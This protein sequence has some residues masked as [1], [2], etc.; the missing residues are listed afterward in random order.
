VRKGKNSVAVL[1]TSARFFFGAKLPLETRRP[2]FSWE[3]SAKPLQ[4][5]RRKNLNSR[6]VVF[7]RLGTAPPAF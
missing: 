6:F 1:H 4:F 2:N 3:N 5:R 7:W